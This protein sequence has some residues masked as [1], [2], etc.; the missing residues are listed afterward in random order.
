M[1][2]AVPSRLRL[3]RRERRDPLRPRDQPPKAL[4]RGQFVHLP[5]EGLL[6]FLGSPWADRPGVLASLGL[7]LADFAL[8]DATTDLLEAFELHRTALADARRLAALLEKRG[9]ELRG[10]NERLSIRNSL[11]ESAEAMTRGLL[12]T[13]PEAFVAVDEHGLVRTF[14]PAA[15]ALFGWKAEEVVGRNVSM[16]MPEPER[17]AHDTHLARYLATGTRH[18]IGSRREVIAVRRDGTVFPCELSVGEVRTSAGLT[19]TGFLRDL[20]AQR[21]AESALR[22]SEADYRS[23]VEG[24]KEVV[25]R[26]DAEGRWAFLNPSW[27][28]VTGFTVE[29]T[30]GRAFLDSV[31]PDDREG[32]TA[33]FAALVAGKKDHCRHEVRYLTRGGD[34][35]WIEVYARL[36]HGPDGL[37]SG[38]T[39]TLYDITERR[40]TESELRRAK[41]AAVE[42]TRLKSKFLANMSHEIRTPLNAVIGMTGLLLETS[43]T[44]EQQEFADTIR[45]SGKTLLEL[46]NEILDFSKIESGR[47]EIVRAP[48]DLRE[49]AEDAIDLVAPQAAEKGLEL[50]LDVDAPS[51]SAWK[52]DEARIRQ[53]VVNLLTNAVKFTSR[54]EVVLSVSAERRE[55]AARSSGSPFGTR[56]PASRTRNATA[57]SWRSPSSIRRRR[58]STAERASAS[59][60]AGAWRRRW[61]AGSR[62]GTH[63]GSRL[64]LR[65]HRAGRG[66]SSAVRH[67]VEGAGQPVGGA[68]PR[69]RRQRRG[70]RG[71]RPALPRPRARRRRRR[72]RRGRSRTR[73]GGGAVRRRRRGHDPPGRAGD[74]R[75]PG[76]PVAVRGEGAFRSP[77]DARSASGPGPPSDADVLRDGE[78]A[79]Q[80]RSALGGPRRRAPGLL[81]RA[82]ASPEGEGGHAPARRREAAA[83]PRRGRQHRQPAR[84]DLAFSRSSGCGRTS[85][86]TASR[87]CRR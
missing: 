14:N 75:L 34:P 60:S 30:L 38:T 35:R 82:A 76:V 46:I 54:G 13:S 71:G 17:G 40:N 79:G 57:S 55:R 18:I 2:P 7:G 63:A 36:T 43:L 62:P 25:F 12:E 24:V 72:L 16:L 20:S 81:G 11:L 47:L 32:N 58:E 51:G 73:I 37:P 10:A 26:T 27:T 56:G 86:R 78:Q 41:E 49:C 85:P 21:A 87:P 33:L 15:E 22:E 70:A 52:G 61:G 1:L 29:E 67:D 77:A 44:G 5:D 68:V 65:S 6:V 19:F 39:G 80:A 66:G 59:R 4:F 50:V 31:H 42:A 9:A 69:G 45:S 8:H 64:P 23:V 84:R 48:F 28:E 3:A 53:V 83:G 74:G